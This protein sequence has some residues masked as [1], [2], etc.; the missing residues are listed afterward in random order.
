MF[1]GIC[2]SIGRE[3]TRPSTRTPTSSQ[4]PSLG[5]SSYQPELTNKNPTPYCNHSPRPIGTSLLHDSQNGC[6][7]P[8]LRMAPAQN[9]RQRSAIHSRQHDG[10]AI[11]WPADPSFRWFCG[12]SLPARK[13]PSAVFSSSMRRG[14]KNARLTPGFDPCAAQCG[15]LRDPASVSF[16]HQGYRCQT[17]HTIQLLSRH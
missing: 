12:C 2:I 7:H 1:T 9:P 4:I 15:S 6:H 16:P 11:F 3:K 8:Q 17:K 5:P 13:T 10:R 14:L